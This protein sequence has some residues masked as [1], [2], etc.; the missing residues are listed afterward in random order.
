MRDPDEL[1]RLTNVFRELGA[2]DP[3]GWARSQVQEGVPQ[4]AR[5]LFLRQAWRGVVSADDPTW[6]GRMIAHAQLSP[7]APYAGAG[8]SLKALR[9]RGATDDE[10]GEL[11]RAMQAELLFHIAYLLDDP[12]DIEPAAGEVAWSLFEVDEDGQPIA[13]VGGLHESV[14]ETDPAGREVRPRKGAG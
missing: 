12:G 5:F 13:P 10:L 3:E 4:L 11:V 6:I 8:H 1:K 9:R 2:S 14:L 7:E